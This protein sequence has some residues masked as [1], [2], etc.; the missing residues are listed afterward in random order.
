M[1]ENLSFGYKTQSLN[2]ILLNA[3]GLLLASAPYLLPSASR[4]PIVT[5]YPKLVK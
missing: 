3:S 2:P 4:L 5:L 1:N